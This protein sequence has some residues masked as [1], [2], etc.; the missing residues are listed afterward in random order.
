MNNKTFSIIGLSILSGFI[1]S[2]CSLNEISVNNQP[3]NTPSNQQNNNIVYNSSKFGF[4]MSYQADSKIHYD[5]E[6]IKVTTKQP[7][8]YLLTLS[9]ENIAKNDPNGDL[10]FNLEIYDTAPTDCTDDWSKMKTVKNLIQ[11]DIVVGGVSTKLVN[12]TGAYDLDYSSVCFQKNGLFYDFN[13]SGSTTTEAKTIR[14]KYFQDIL[15]SFK[16][17]KS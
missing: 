3:V 14:D 8:K 1:L 4:S 9:N 13:S 7:Y 17:T 2:G 5:S 11:K 10:Y 6:A 12:F 16:F 15:S